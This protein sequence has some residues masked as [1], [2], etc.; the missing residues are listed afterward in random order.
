MAS[1][2]LVSAGSS[3][4]T[5]W[6]RGGQSVTPP[7]L[8]AAKKGCEESFKA[9]EA[10]L[11][12]HDPQ[13]SIRFQLMCKNKAPGLGDLVS[14]VDDIVKAANK[15]HPTNN[16]TFATRFIKLLERVKDFATIGDVFVGGAQNMVV[17]GV[18][19]TVRLAIEVCSCRRPAVRI[20]LMPF[21]DI[22]LIVDL[23]REGFRLTVS[24]RQVLGVEC[25]IRDVV[26]GESRTTSACLRISRYC[27]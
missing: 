23:L 20:I 4:L 27:R 9:F 22:S 1:S 16:R 17:S 10:A 19:G 18:W 7:A 11:R 3:R 12:K 25:R 15:R 2:S 6:G 26:S 8:K 24:G 14:T 5:P 13:M 21:A